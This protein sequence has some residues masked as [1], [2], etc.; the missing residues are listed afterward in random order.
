[1]SWN[2]IPLRGAASISRVANIYEVQ[3]LRAPST[4]YRIKV[5]ERALGDFLAVPNLCVKTRTGE[6]DWIAGLGR[7]ELEALEDAIARMGEALG[8][9]ERL[10]PDD[11]EWSDPHDF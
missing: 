2:A 8:A 7:T 3:D 6:P 11:F 4:R 1:M 5:L 9:A 10:T